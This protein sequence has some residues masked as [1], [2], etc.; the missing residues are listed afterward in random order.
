MQ[1]ESMTQEELSTRIRNAD[2]FCNLYMNEISLFDGIILYSGEDGPFPLTAVYRQYDE[3]IERS[4]KTEQQ[5]INQK[6]VDI[7]YCGKD[8]YIFISYS[9]KD[10]Q[11]ILPILR[12]MQGMG[13]RV[14]YDDGVRGGQNWRKVIYEKIHDC[15]DFLLFCSEASMTSPYVE[16]EMDAADMAHRRIIPVLLDEKEYPFDKQVRLC[17]LEFLKDS[18][19]L[20]DQLQD[21]LSGACRV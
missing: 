19:R 1:D 15:T 16:E 11:A 10:K 17:R 5:L 20:A 6:Y 21:T 13:Y 3:M 9:R 14:W 7:P 4:R 12:R 2:T 8:P 18:D